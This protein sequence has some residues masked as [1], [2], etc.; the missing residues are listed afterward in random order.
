M[1]ILVIE[2]EVKA[3]EFVRKALTGEQCE[4]DVCHRGDEGLD[5]ALANPYDAIVLDIMLPG[6][7]GLS[8]LRVLRERGNNT[9]VLL[10]SARSH[11]TERVDGLNA[12]ADD[13]LAKPF[14][15]EELSA[16]VKALCRRS[17]ESRSVH[18]KVGNLV[19]DTVT[20]LARRGSQKVELSAREFRLLE[21]LMRH[22]GQVCTRMLLLEKVWD[23]DF[24]PGTNL[25]DVAVRRLRDRLEVPGGEPLIH[26]IR[27]QGYMIMTPP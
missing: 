27:G 1:K 25:V 15:L 7:D 9:P 26:T 3:A 24:D 13:Y 2:D 6:R 16:R 23:Y 4:V 22:P 8:V 11:V 21:F 12:G 14:A 19:L 5:R 17:G 18:L 20:R 10:L